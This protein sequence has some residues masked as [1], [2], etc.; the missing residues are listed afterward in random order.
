MNRNSAS[1]GTPVEHA[2]LDREGEGTRLTE[3]EVRQLVDDASVPVLLMLA[4]QMSGDERW[5]S[6]RYRP[7]KFR[8]VAPRS[9][10]GLPADVQQ[11]VREAAVGAILALQ[12]G[13][14]LQ[15]TL[16][17][18]DTTARVAS[19]FL[20]ESVDER[21]AAILA[22]ELSRR[23][24]S[25]G[26]VGSLPDVTAPAGLRVAIIGMGISGLAAVHIAQ[27]LGLEFTVFERASG[28]G[29]VWHQ[30][31]YPGAGVDTPSHLYSFSFSYRDW[32]RHFE[33]QEQ[34]HEYFNDVLDQLDARS[35]VQFD[36]EVLS[37]VYDDET[38]L[39]TLTVRRRDGTVEKHV[40][41]MVISGVGS[42]NQ[43]RLP[44]VPGMDRFEGVQFH[45]N[46][47]RPGID[48]AG[49]K[50]AI[51]GVG[52]SCQ[53]I[54]PEIAPT[55]AELTIVQRS[56]QW[57]APFEQFRTDIPAS[58][59][60]LLERVPLYRAWNWVGLF[61]Q[62]GDKIIDA[63]R[64]DPEWKH[65][66]RS[67]NA[68]NDRQRE[69]LTRYIEQSLEGRPDLIQK[70]IPDYPPF[71]KRMLLDNGWF[72]MLRRDNVTLQADR[73]AAVDE[74]GLVLGSGDH[75]DADVIIWATGFHATHF[76]SS[77]QVSGENGVLLR[78]QWEEDDPRAF[79][80]VSIPHFPNFFMLGGPH[81]L[82][83]SGSF[84]YFMELQARYLRNLLAEMFRKGVTAIDA[85][86][87]ATDRYND[88]VDDL[89]SRTVWSHPGFGT[90][91]RNSK[92]R[93][94][95]VMPFLNVEYWE[96][97]REPNLA[98]YEL[99]DVAFVPAGSAE[100]G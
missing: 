13:A 96:F 39:W 17:D 77:V 20:G 91:Y 46:E 12:D 41:N 47:W 63:L 19:F 14:P 4:Y 21:Y 25:D 68:R 5:L 61:W 78:D 84:M 29:G 100:C 35:K 49:K 85:T 1:G 15:V 44:D 55:V 7:E 36:T 81:S 97:V 82:P 75:V 60:A 69:F 43:P 92:G 23:A 70:S 42:L 33:L 18:V 86:D 37:A 64:I 52:A 34:L 62:H 58:E 56:P 57:V 99:R 45:S 8:G 10:G 3:D 83:G 27:Q 28:A 26:E 93:V 89:H 66:E 95:F 87:A 94:I 48:L 71:G 50:V 22:E 79:L 74:R 90:Y 2:T 24:S 40:A 80:G 88:M 73:V 38:A 67:V 76:L 9:T 54:A 51:V 16:D 65:P 6:D 59:R 32:G 98:D 72:R 53:Q 30:N 31:R 11:E